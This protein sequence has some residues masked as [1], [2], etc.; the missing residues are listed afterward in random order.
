MTKK[1]FTM[2]DNLATKLV[3]TAKSYKTSQS[4]IVSTALTLYLMLDKFAPSG[5]KK[6]TDLQNDNQVDIYDV[7]KEAERITKR[8]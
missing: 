5:M 1:I 7:L 8:K 2:D 6:V 4:R 3:Q